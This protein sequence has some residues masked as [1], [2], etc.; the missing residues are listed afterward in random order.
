M[1]LDVTTLCFY[2]QFGHIIAAH[3]TVMAYNIL[4][5][6]LFTF[7]HYCYPQVLIIKNLGALEVTVFVYLI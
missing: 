6:P 5:I 4:S 7:H 1:V 2:L 3:E